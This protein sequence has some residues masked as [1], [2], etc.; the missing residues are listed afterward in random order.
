[1]K[2]ESAAFASSPP[3]TICTCL[4]WLSADLLVAGCSDGHVAIW[5]MTKCLQAQRIALDATGQSSSSV[6]FWYHSLHSTYIIS[7]AAHQPYPGEYITTNGVD[8]K[9]RLTSIRNPYS[10]SAYGSRE[11]HLMPPLVYSP[12]ILGIY[13]IDETDG[14]RARPLRH[15]P[16][17]RAVGRAPAQVL[18]IDAGKVHPTLLFGCA[19]G[20]AILTNPMRRMYIRRLT[21][22]RVEAWQQTWFR[23][24]F[25]PTNRSQPTDYTTSLQ[26][27][28]QGTSYI[29]PRPGTSRFLESFKLEAVS[30]MRNIQPIKDDNSK[31]R[32]DPEAGVEA[33]SFSSPEKKKKKTKQRRQ[34]EEENIVGF[35]DVQVAIFEEEQAVT[36]LCWNPN[37][38]TGGW[39]AAGM[40]NGLIRVEDL[41]V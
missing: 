24:E 19:D 37:I 26:R 14:L 28:L 41:A 40:A 34:Q 20:N 30:L 39:A 11:R 32:Q 38:Q 12:H 9:V 23:H 29:R 31:K 22:E 6:P 18:C 8:G 36:C 1:M 4:T 2:Y 25:V 33:A 13:E 10:D 16:V 3:D 5:S 15:M 21:D 17:S 7:V 27:D 35:E